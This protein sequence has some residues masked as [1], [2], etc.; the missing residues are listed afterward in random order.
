MAWVGM[1]AMPLAAQNDAPSAPASAAPGTNSPAPATATAAPGTPSQGTSAAKAPDAQSS[2]TSPNAVTLD[3]SETLFAVLASINHCGY[4]AELGVSNPL[5]GQIREEI[6]KN[7]KASTSAGEASQLLC[8]FYADHQTGDNAHTLAQ[9]V[10]LALYLTPPPD[11][12][13]K[14]KDADLPPDASVISG[15]IPFMDKFYAEAGLHNIWMAHHAAYAQLTYLYHDPVAKM[16]FDTEAYL[17][18]PSAG[19]L[20]HSF[21]VYLDPQGAPGQTNARN[22]GADYYVVISPGQDTTL[23]MEQVRH[24][25]LHYLLDPMTLKYPG[26]IKQLDPLLETVKNAPI[27]ASF[28]TSSALLMTECLIRAIEA[29]TAGSN[30]APE[31]VRQQAVQESMEQGYILTRY[32]YD[33]L[34]RFEKDSTGFRNAYANMIAEI[35]VSREKKAAQ[36]IQ[37]A[38]KADPEILHL[39]QPMQGKLLVTAEQRLSA[40]DAATAQKLAQEVLDEKSGDAGQALFI[41]ARAATMQRDMD[42]AKKYFEETL[43]VA[44]EP[45]LVAWSHIYLGRI[46]D[47]QEERDAALDHY[48]AALTAGGELPEVKAAAE[49]GIQTP[50]EPPARP[51]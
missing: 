15:V 5:R 47:L 33:A 42:G 20:G 51:Q 49:R 13:V 36:Q 22:Y 35:D 12:S 34:A 40:G 32:F 2:P 48:H 3:T 43:S 10:S 23:K 30:R 16:L 8:Q 37:F 50:Y 45:R 26:A 4:D 25:Y 31:A 38:V 21:T 27:D 19:Y 9:Y 6:A 18:L 28:K 24:T 14:G 29:R 7:V 17:K 44:H 39:A 41:M 1:M 46:F 11:L